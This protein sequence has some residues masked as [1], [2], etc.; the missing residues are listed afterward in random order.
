MKSAMPNEEIADDPFSYA[1]GEEPP[2]QEHAT[3]GTCAHCGEQA[4]THDHNGL[5]ACFSCA[6]SEANW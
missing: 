3:I 1:P 5:F 4:K 2:E 6:Y